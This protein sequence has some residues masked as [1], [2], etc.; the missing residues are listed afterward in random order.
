MSWKEVETAWHDLVDRILA[1]WPE[2][3]AERVMALAGDRKA[4]TTYIAERHDLT[5]AEAADAIEM[6]MYRQMTGQRG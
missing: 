5:L 6:W 1:Q 2:A 3:S 4:F